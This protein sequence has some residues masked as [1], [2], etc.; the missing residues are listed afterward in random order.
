LAQILILLPEDKVAHCRLGYFLDFIVGLYLLIVFFLA[1]DIRELLS[2][3]E[4]TLL[5]LFSIYNKK[6][7]FQV[8]VLD[9]RIFDAILKR[10]A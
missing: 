7:I 10:E 9:E 2:Q 3:M 8:N 5:I 4:Q 6:R 1:Q